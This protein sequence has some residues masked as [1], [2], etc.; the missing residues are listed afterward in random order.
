MSRAGIRAAGCA[1]ALVGATASA[2]AGGFGIP[3]LG[4][5]RTGMGAEIGRPDDATA[6]FH[7]PAGLVLSPDLQLY[8]GAGVALLDTT[9]S[10]AP[11]DSSNQ[12]LGVQPQA[13]GYYAPVKPS[14]AIGVIPFLGVTDVVTRPRLYLGAALYVGNGTGAK[15][16]HDAVT[17]YDLIDGYVIS[18][19]G[20]LAA[21]VRINHAIS[22]GGTIGEMNLRIHG[23]RDV[24]PIF[25]GTNISGLAGTNSDLVLDGSAWAPTWSLGVFGQP[26]PRVS[27]GLSLVG[28]V[29]AKVAGPIDVTYG[30]D[31]PQPGMKLTGTQITSQL[32]P[33]TFLGG[34]N[35]DITPHVELGVD[36][37]YWLYR[38]YKEQHTDVIGI[39]LLR[40]LDTVKDYHDSQQVSGGV[41]VHDLAGLP[42]VELMGGMHYDHSPAPPDTL[43][44]DS[45][46]FS[47]VGVHS[48]VRYAWSRYRASLTYVH[49]WYL[50]PT[51][52]DSTTM[53]PLNFEGSGQNNIITLSFEAKL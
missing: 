42:G 6:I 46:S 9:F 28:R 39:F 11:W 52:T 48:G 23:E 34:V 16:H 20:A 50:V 22:V 12:Y 3:E 26:H 8:V 27:Y 53:P 18:P 2:H 7:D 19:Q 40:S 30:T 45:P 51:V 31:S 36:L 14:R 35:V 17:R 38:Q 10:L 33:W 4:A 47:H 49:Y 5:R 24:Y 1:L 44:L 21:A 32:L 41:R 15:F 13:N 25:N 37:R 29:D 43:T